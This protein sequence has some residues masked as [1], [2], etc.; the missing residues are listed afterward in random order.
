MR[1]QFDRVRLAPAGHFASL[2]QAADDTHV[3]PT[4]VDQVLFDRFAKLPL[5]GPL[6]ARCDRHRGLLPQAVV[7]V[8]ILRAQRVLH[9]EGSVLLALATQAHGVGQIESGMYI[10]TELDVVADG[11]AHCFQLLQGRPNCDS[12]LQHVALL[13]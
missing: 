9:E 12:R 3:D 13:R 5:A 2:G 10:Q 4:V 8:W 11:G 7:Q 1:D 6:L